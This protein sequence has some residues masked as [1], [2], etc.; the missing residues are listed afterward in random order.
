VI[1]S[2]S[3]QLEM[4]V[5]PKETERPSKP[6]AATVQDINLSVPAA[7]PKLNDLVNS[8]SYPQVPVHYNVA[9]HHSET[10]NRENANGF[11]SKEPQEEGNDEGSANRMDVHN[12]TFIPSGADHI[13]DQDFKNEAETNESMQEGSDSE[14][15]D[16]VHSGV[17]GDTQQTRQLND[18]V[19]EDENPQADDASSDFVPSEAEQSHSES[20]ESEED[21]EESEVAQRRRRPSKKLDIDDLDPELYG[22]RRSGRSRVSNVRY[23]V[24]SA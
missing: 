23:G 21:S 10:T 16:V 24:I 3:F 1:R 4:D 14:F 13:T 6:E 17:N 19:E 8:A 20:E 7:A 15:D 18:S 5:D 9:K 12:D 22:L 11:T 2:Q